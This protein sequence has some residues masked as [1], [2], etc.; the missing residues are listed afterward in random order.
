LDQN[1]GVIATSGPI[2]DTVLKAVAQVLD[3]A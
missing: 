3:P 1:S 2:H